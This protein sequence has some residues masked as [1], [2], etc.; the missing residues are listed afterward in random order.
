VYSAATIPADMPIR[1]SEREQFVEYPTDAERPRC[2]GECID[3]PRPCPWVSCKHNLYLDVNRAT[4]SIKLNFPDIELE[5]LA[6]TCALDVADRGGATLEE[7]ADGLN[8]TRERVRQ[9]EMMAF[10]KLQ[11]VVDADD[12]LDYSRGND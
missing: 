11:K 6:E 9:I 5:E 3:A 10:E 4:G 12:V 7:V 8:L 2:R 1:R